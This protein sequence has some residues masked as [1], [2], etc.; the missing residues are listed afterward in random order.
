MLGGV[1]GKI[2]PESSTPQLPSTSREH[3]VSGLSSMDRAQFKAMLLMFEVYFQDV[4]CD[5]I[6]M[7]KGILDGSTQILVKGSETCHR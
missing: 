5:L 7:H 3:G 6:G 2:C 4:P 1:R